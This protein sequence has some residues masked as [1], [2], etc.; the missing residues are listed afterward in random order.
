M[1]GTVGKMHTYML[2]KERE[3]YKFILIVWKLKS[4]QEDFQEMKLKK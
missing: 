4:S 1:S 3:N 2:H